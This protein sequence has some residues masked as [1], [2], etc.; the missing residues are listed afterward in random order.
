MVRPALVVGVFFALTACQV[1]HFAPPAPPPPPNP[2]ALACKYSTYSCVGI[3]PPTILKTNSMDDDALG[4]YVFGEDFVRVRPQGDEVRTAIVVA[5]EL[6][7]YLQWIHGQELE[8]KGDQCR[9][10]HEAFDVSYAV[11]I[12][13]KQPDTQ[14]EEIKWAYGCPV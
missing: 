10:E 2:W 14:W 5:H 8:T 11:S 7:H 12:E 4:Q 1:Q 3:T 9:L 13:L 6:V